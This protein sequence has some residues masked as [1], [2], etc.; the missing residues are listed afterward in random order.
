MLRI[1]AQL[2]LWVSGIIAGLF[3]AKDAPN[4]PMWQM[5][6]GLLFLVVLSLAIWWITNPKSSDK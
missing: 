6:F 1:I 2:V 3:V 4:F 5:T